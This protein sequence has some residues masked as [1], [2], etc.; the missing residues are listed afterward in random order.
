M[1][2]INELGK[3]ISEENKKVL[4][5]SLMGRAFTYTINLW[6]S[7]QNFLYNGDLQIDNN[8]IENSIRPNALGRKNYL[9]AGSHLGAQRSA[10]FY[11]FMGTCK[12][13]GV[14]PLKWMTFVLDNIADHKVNRLWE[15][16]PQNVEV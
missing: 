13:N 9:F 12:M 8:L 4:P 2:I 6:D 7:L 10:M 1:P 5:K 16:F 3:W 15:L 14:D 11:T